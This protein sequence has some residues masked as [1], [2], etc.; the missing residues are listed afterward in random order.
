MRGVRAAWGGG[1][2]EGRGGA[3]REVGGLA[4]R[5]TRRPSEPP[6]GF[7]CGRGPAWSPRGPAE[8]CTGWGTAFAFQAG[9]IR[10]VP[11]HA[12]R[13]CCHTHLLKSKGI[14]PS[15]PPPG[16]GALQARW[17]AAPRGSQPAANAASG[18]PAPAGRPSPPT[19][20][21]ASSRREVTLRS[22][23]WAPPPPPAA[24]SAAPLKGPGGWGRGLGAGTE[25][26]ALAGRAVGLEAWRGREHPKIQ[27]FMPSQLPPPTVFH[28][29]SVALSKS[30]CLRYF[31]FANQFS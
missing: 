19:L 8:A 29:F 13:G 6:A 17:A 5:C 18:R 22:T 30:H 10:S 12:P 23:H 16:M 24:P 4:S 11:E 3:A 27:L 20:A 21:A 31:A 14:V 28:Q 7:V 1:P 15:P 25:G 2:L 26:R 9:G